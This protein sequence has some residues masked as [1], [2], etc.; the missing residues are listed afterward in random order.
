[1]GARGYISKTADEEEIGKALD[2]I[3]RGEVY[4]E[5]HL[6]LKSS[7]MPDIYHSLTKKERIILDLVKKRFDNRDIARELSIKLRTVENY[8]SRIYAKTGAGSRGE[9]YRI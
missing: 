1:M 7:R 9:L 6:G 2:Q 8:M 3:L 5:E 4:I